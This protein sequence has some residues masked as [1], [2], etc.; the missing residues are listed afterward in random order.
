MVPLTNVPHIASAYWNNMD[1][2][3][4]YAH[5]LPSGDAE[6]TVIRILEQL[7][8]KVDYVFTDAITGEATKEA[9]VQA[10]RDEAYRL[11]E[12]L[13]RDV[14][15]EVRPWGEFVKSR[16][17]QVGSGAAG[18]YSTSLLDGISSSGPG[19]VFV[20]GVMEKEAVDLY[21]WQGVT[22]FSIGIKGD[23][24]GPTRP[25]VAIDTFRS[26]LASY[27]FQ[28]IHNK[29][30]HVG[31]DVG[32]SPSQEFAR[33]LSLSGMSVA[34]KGFIGNNRPALA[35]YDFK[36]W[37]HY[38][39]YCEQRI[40]KE[41]MYDLSKMYIRDDEAR[42]DVCAALQKMIESHD[43]AIY[44]SAVFAEARLKTKID[45]MLAQA[46]SR[47]FYDGVGTP[48]PTGERIRQVGQSNKSYL[49]RCSA[50]QQSGRWETLEGNTEIS[51]TRLALRDRELERKGGPMLKALLCFNRADD[52]AEVYSTL[53]AAVESVKTMA[54]IGYQANEKKQI[55]SRRATIYFRIIYANGSMRGMPARSV[56]SVLTVP[57]AKTA[58]KLP[59]NVAVIKAVATNCERAVRR[60]LDP[61]L[62]VRIYCEVSSYFSWVTLLLDPKGL[63]PIRFTPEEVKRLSGANGVCITKTKLSFRIR[64]EVLEGAPSE[65]GLGVLRPGTTWYSA[66]FG[67]SKPMFVKQL[68]ELQRNMDKITMLGPETPGAVEQ[69]DSVAAYLGE[70]LGVEVPT[71]A[72]E[73]YRADLRRGIVA[74]DGSGVSHIVMR[75]ISLLSCCRWPRKTRMRGGPQVAGLNRTVCAAVQEAIKIRAEVT[76]AKDSGALTWDAVARR[77]G[78]FEG[79]PAYGCLKKLWNGFGQYVVRHLHGHELNEFVDAVMRYASTTRELSTTLSDTLGRKFLL[80][81]LLGEFEPISMATVQLPAGLQQFAKGLY[82]NY[83]LQRL[84]ASKG[85]ITT[86]EGWLETLEADVMCTV[87][88]ALYVLAPELLLN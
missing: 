36:K 85:S 24:R 31:W 13:Y 18:A 42:N 66:K 38:V 81:Y 51:R 62:M 88:E 80:K 76:A 3:V 83:F 67:G 2:N 52:V 30:A 71:E 9:Y 61:G 64:R 82:R 32:E 48:V 78:T 57:P 79:P 44:T 75:R 22:Q 70:S 17:T 60:G 37:D 21:T 73:Q 4:G 56:Y 41:V 50:T 8:A 46:N 86:A 47:P 43:L 87:M 68:A 19:K 54:A 26:L 65:G 55:V 7:T 35:A 33:Y 63:A 16:V 77:C 59:H 25:I 14:A 34:G 29:Y 58:G 12:P 11:L 69:A 20:M 53:Y 6:E 74:S 49:V 39:Q 10:F 45:E 15:R 40:I 27:A 23:E 5:T 1:A 28:P 84:E 72:T